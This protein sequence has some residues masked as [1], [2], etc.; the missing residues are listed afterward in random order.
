MQHFLIKGFSPTK[1]IP[2]HT[3]QRVDAKHLETPKG[4]ADKTDL[5]NALADSNNGYFARVS[6]MELSWDEMRAAS[7]RFGF[8]QVIP[9]DILTDASVAKT[10]ETDWNVRMAAGFRHTEL[11]P[12]A[13]LIIGA[14]AKDGAAIS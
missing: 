10:Y 6:D 7:H 9:F 3:K 11:T 8:N 5:A 13:A 12:L 4:P 1:I 2:T 14:V